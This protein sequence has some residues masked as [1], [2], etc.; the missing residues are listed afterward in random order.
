[1][2]VCD[3]SLLTTSHLTFNGYMAKARPIKIFPQYF[4]IGTEKKREK[5]ESAVSP[6]VTDSDRNRERRD[7]ELQ[8][9]KTRDRRESGRYLCPLI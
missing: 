7:E 9:A 4:E 8:R 6:S 2:L 3:P 5:K 1:M